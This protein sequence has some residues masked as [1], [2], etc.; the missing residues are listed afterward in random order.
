MDRFGVY[1]FAVACAAL[2]FVG[3]TLLLLWI[4]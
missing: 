4:V 2:L 3:A 1:A